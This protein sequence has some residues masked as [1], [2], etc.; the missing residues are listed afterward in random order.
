[1]KDGQSGV[2]VSSREDHAW[3]V[4][5]EKLLVDRD[6]HDRLAAGA[7]AHARSFSWD[8]TTQGLQKAYTEALLN[9]PKT[10][11]QKETGHQ[12]G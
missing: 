2:L 11:K 8:R 12:A 4:A 5:I 3:A 1:V 9:F 10:T 7:L 6:Y